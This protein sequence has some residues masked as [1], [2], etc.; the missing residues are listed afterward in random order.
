MCTP[1]RCPRCRN[2]NFAWLFA[3]PVSRFTVNKKAQSLMTCCVPRRAPINGLRNRIAGAPAVPHHY[4]G[5]VGLGRTGCSNSHRF[6]SPAILRFG[7]SLLLGVCL[8][9]LLTRKPFIIDF[10]QPPLEHDFIQS[11][12]RSSRSSS[13]SSV[14]APVLAAA[15]ATAGGGGAGPPTS[16]SSSKAPRA[17]ASAAAQGLHR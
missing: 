5:R 14:A 12:S 13:P 10:S 8:V 1:V 9:S 3:P 2:E 16:S 15:A 6:S 17:A 7:C 4:F 11:P